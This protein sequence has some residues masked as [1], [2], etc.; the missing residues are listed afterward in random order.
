MTYQVHAHS[1]TCWK[2][3]KNNVVSHIVDILLRREL[4][5]NH[6]ILNLAMMK[7]KKVLTWR[8]ALLKQVKSYIDINL[9]SA[10]LNVIDPTKDNFT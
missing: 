2:Y 10:K 3:N 5:Q 7:K 8:N 1:I 9:T 4:L 6:L